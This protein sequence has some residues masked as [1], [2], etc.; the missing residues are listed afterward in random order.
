MR[1]IAQIKQIFENYHKAIDDYR[2]LEIDMRTFVEDNNYAL[3]GQ[4]RHASINSV[5]INEGQMTIDVDFWGTNPGGYYGHM[6]IR[7]PLDIYADEGKLKKW[8]ADV[9][10]SRQEEVDRHHKERLANEE[11]EDHKTIKR[12]MGKYGM[13]SYRLFRDSLDQ[14][15]VEEAPQ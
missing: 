14:P 9:A 3:T 5:L 1:T 6:A 15:V 8:L 2:R 7:L 11:L 13:T 12:L 4:T 10:T